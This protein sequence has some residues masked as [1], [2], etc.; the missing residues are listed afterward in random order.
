MV[1]A[2]W[3]D[4]ENLVELINDY[5][6]SEVIDKNRN[7]GSGLN[8]LRFDIMANLRVDDYGGNRRAKLFIK[9]MRIST[10]R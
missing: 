8:D 9:D 4:G 2:V 3:F 7:V 10:A 1:S 5:C 6:H